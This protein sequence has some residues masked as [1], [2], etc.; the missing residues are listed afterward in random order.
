MGTNM[1]APPP[2][3]DAALRSL[4]ARLAECATIHLSLL[5]ERFHLERF[6][7]L[8]PDLSNPLSV[9]FDPRPDSEQAQRDVA[10]DVFARWR[11]ENGQGDELAVRFGGGKRTRA[12]RS[13]AQPPRSVAQQQQKMGS[14]ISRPSERAS[15]SRRHAKQPSPVESAPVPAPTRAS[16]RKLQQVQEP[17][18]PPLLEETSRRSKTP[19][20][21][22]GKAGATVRVEPAAPYIDPLD[23]V[24]PLPPRWTC[25]EQSP[26]S[27]SAVE[28]TSASSSGTGDAAAPVS[29]TAGL[30]LVSPWSPPDPPPLS[31]TLDAFRYL[32]T[33]APHAIVAAT[34]ASSSSKDAAESR[35]L[36]GDT[37]AAMIALTYREVDPEGNAW[38]QHI[39]GQVKTRDRA[40]RL[41]RDRGGLAGRPVPDG[42]GLGVKRYEEE[43][44]GGEA[45]GDAAA[46]TAAVL[47][48]APTVS[49]A[50]SITRAPSHQ[51]HLLVHV[52][53]VRNAML[54]VHK[55]SLAGARRVARMAQQHWDLEA[56]REEREQQ[57]LEADAR[58]AHRLVVKALKQ[59]WKMA[60]RVIRARQEQ[61]A[62][63]ERE[64]LGKEQVKEMIERSTDLLRGGGGGEADGE[65]AEM[66]VLEVAHNPWLDPDEEED[67]KSEEEEEAPD[68]EALMQRDRRRAQSLPPRDTP[69]T[70]VA[71]RAASLPPAESI[72]AVALPP[73]ACSLDKGAQRRHFATES[74]QNTLRTSHRLRRKRRGQSLPRAIKRIKLEGDD[75]DAADIEY[76]MDESDAAEEDRALDAQMEAEDADDES[77]EDE[78]LAQ[79][80]DL[81]L[82]QV[83]KSYGYDDD[84]IAR[85][86]RRA[87][88]G[89]VQ[90]EP[91]VEEV[92][93][94]T[95]AEEQ[96]TIEHPSPSSPPPESTFPVPFLLRAEL[97]PYQLAG[98]EW[99]ARAY[100]NKI[101]A[102]LAD[103]MG[104]GK[105]LQTI[106]LLAHL[107]CDLGIWGPH[108]IVVPSSVILNW[109]REFHRF[110]PGCKVLT[111]YGSQAERKAKRK[112]WDAENAFQV[113]ITSYQIAIA[114]QH[115]LRRKNWHYMVLD[116][117]HLIKNYRSQR[118]QT[119]LTFKSARR[120]LLTGTPLQNNL[121]DVWS[122]LRFLMPPDQMP[123]EGSDFATW[124]SNPMELAI[125][126][127]NID[128]AET[129]EMVH[130]L[131]VILRP[132]ILRR[133]KSEVETQ[134]PEKHEHVIYCQLSKRQRFL[135]DEFMSRSSTR[136]NLM[137]GGYMAVAS[138]LMQLR[139][140]VNH[141]DLFEVRPVRTSFAMRPSLVYEHRRCIKAMPRT[142]RPR[143]I[144][145]AFETSPAAE[146]RRRLDASEEI[147]LK[148]EIPHVDADVRTKAGWASYR[149]Y[150]I[151]Q[152]E[153]SRRNT[154]AQ[155][156]ESRCRQHPVFGDDLVR[157]ARLKSPSRPPNLNLAF[158]EE[159]LD[160]L[161]KF[162]FCTPNAVAPDLADLALG[163]SL[164][165]VPDIDHPDFDTLHHAQVKLQIAFP[166]RSLLQYDCGK[167]QVLAG[168]LKDLK[169][170][171]H[172]VIIFTQMT[173]MLDILENFLN[174]HGH[175]YSRLDGSTKIEDRLLITERFN[176]S[177]RIFCFIAST[178]S[179]GVGINLTG[180]DTV[181]FYDNEFNPAMDKQ[182]Q[183]RAHRI[184]QTRE[185]NI[186]RL[187]TMHTVEENMLKKANQKRMLDNVVIQEGNFTTDYLAKT[188]LRDV[189]GDEFF[190]SNGPEGG[191]SADLAITSHEMQAA[192]AQAEDA[193]DVAAAQLAGAEDV[194]AGDMSE[195]DN[196]RS[197]RSVSRATSDTPLPEEPSTPAIDEQAIDE[198]A[199]EDEEP[200]DDGEPGAVDEYMLRLVEWEHES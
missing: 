76:Q 127:G 35:P 108:L 178:R 100:K 11:S 32:P 68:L 33:V 61:E 124:F 93:S 27:W 19:K 165:D 94:A 200:M 29:A 179:G 166:D 99:L 183:D 171:G 185:V 37:A 65:E 14:I 60:A 138:T 145:F 149:R 26:W 175:T 170:A 184:G 163:S 148:N 131:H 43:S 97:R 78:G 187:V 47:R 189:L 79:D 172:R 83:L 66:D 72:V 59:K 120:L 58:A 38:R 44:N 107:A 144:H 125:E 103:E 6:V 121:N 42:M 146:A 74:D 70:E 81:P 123:A 7:T 151:A 69:L 197:R 88:H 157:A 161:E 55:A 109:E 13:V 188:D 86:A 75:P 117:A 30:A 126:R 116:E 162:A 181:I 49:T 119:L 2:D 177:S 80:A 168:M 21:R 34:A 154:L 16:K 106:A 105:T 130:R 174:F 152:V 62:E 173:R 101:N 135:Y 186:Y 39:Q 102:I 147:A 129:R 48:A 71:P 54:A 155:L 180:A 84:A 167:L 198:P 122:L 190:Q 45:G 142:T 118:W 110:M 73:A 98:L 96:A 176:T 15:S 56:T 112:G 8:L 113:C 169:S 28:L 1:T 140:V 139:K 91:E 53:Q 137:T 141:P 50:T 46:A 17:A 132:Y 12:R 158:R 159:N 31:V 92:A 128:S 20:A 182:A 41:I 160:V 192:L 36:A 153:R 82:E 196:D 193:E 195:Q 18:P 89:S 23:L 63:R 199:E 9:G 77:E 64:R 67:E 136:Q 90:S 156:N 52:V 4:E 191:P 87:R 164:A 115:I 194:E 150:Q 5:R 111:Y 40:R 133:L 51:D 3:K 22:G 24:H 114:D 104:L 10:S 85:V 95:E 143:A 134:L 57:R 25:P